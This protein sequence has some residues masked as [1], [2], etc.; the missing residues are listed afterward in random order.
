MMTLQAMSPGGAA[1][2][3]AGDPRDLRPARRK[4]GW[5]WRGSRA[6]SR[7]SRSTTSIRCSTPRSRA[8]WPRRSVGRS[9]TEKLREKLVASL[10]EAG[11]RGETSYRAKRFHSIYQSLAP[12]DR[13][14][15]AYDYLAFRIVT[16]NLRDTYAVPSAV[17][18]NWRP[19]PG[20]FKLTT[21]R[22]PSR[23]STSPCTRRY[24]GRLGQPFEVQ[25]R[26]R[27]MDSSWPRKESP[28]TGA[29]RR[30]SWL[31][32]GGPEGPVV[33][34]AARAA[35]RG[36]RDP[37]RFLSGLKL[38]LYQDEVYVFSPKGEVLAFLRDATPLDF[39]YR[40]HTDLG[41]PG[42]N[43]HARQRPSGAA[44]DAAPHRGHRRDPGPARA[45]V[46]VAT[47]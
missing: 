31:R 9:A 2:D 17:H 29:T 19:I 8:S 28:H 39:A 6:S 22:C 25:I 20:R 13:D 33:A 40:I 37:R 14:L 16:T 24:W 23:T 1:P 32:R 46:R 26:T 7:T 21:S 18:Q 30:A 41:A 4:P 5:G 47:G 43:R 12:G 15:R 42:K 36:Q 38:D 45:A 44:Q 3:L 11:Y 35:D 27:E 34:S 10:A